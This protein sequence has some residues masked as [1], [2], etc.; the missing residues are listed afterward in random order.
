MLR[1]ECS[2]TVLLINVSLKLVALT[3][4]F[5]EVWFPRVN[6]DIRHLLFLIGLIH[7][8]IRLTLHKV[9]LFFASDRACKNMFI[10]CTSQS[11]QIVEL[12]K[13]DIKSRLAH[14]EESSLPLVH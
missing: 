5:M 6:T 1:S 4:N 14:R 9:I 3:N 13:R 7:F 8:T 10:F 2:D 11:F 12:K